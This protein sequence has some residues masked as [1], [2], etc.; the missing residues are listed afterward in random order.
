MQV[1]FCDLDKFSLLT[2]KNMPLE[3][4]LPTETLLF[5]IATKVPVSRIKCRLVVRLQI[6]VN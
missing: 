1:Y 2:L 4:S 3:E 5:Y 6:V